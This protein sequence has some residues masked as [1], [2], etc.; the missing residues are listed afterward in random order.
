[1]LHLLLHHDL[2]SLNGN[3]GTSRQCQVYMFWSELIDD[4]YLGQNAKLQ[5]GLN[6]MCFIQAIPAAC[7]LIFVRLTLFD[8][9]LQHKIQQIWG[10]SGN[11]NYKSSVKNTAWWRSCNPILMVTMGGDSVDCTL[12]DRPAVNAACQL[13]VDNICVLVP[14]HVGP[15]RLLTQRLP[16]CD[17]DWS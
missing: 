8:F 10:M 7:R 4:G 16:G 1:M 17:W 5:L 11:T 9:C 12:P 13:A 2:Q 15:L 14:C 6:L 3:P